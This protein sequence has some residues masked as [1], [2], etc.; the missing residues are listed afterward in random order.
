MSCV[1]YQGKQL[2]LLD[3]DTVLDVLLRNGH[4]IPHGCRAGAC[5]SCLMVAETGQVPAVAQQG[6][7][8]AQQQLNYFLSC[9]CLPTEP[10]HVSAV[11]QVKES[12]LGVIAEKFWFNDQVIC[13]RLKVADFTY[14]P[15]Q[16]VT[17]WNDEN[18]ARSYSIASLPADGYLEFHIKYHVDGQFSRWLVENAE[19]GTTLTVQGPLGECIYSAEEQQPILLAAIGTGLAPI[20]GIL[21]DALVKGHEGPIRV[22]VGARSAQSHYLVDELLCLAKTYAQVEVYLLAMDDN[23]E[24]ILQKDIYQF[25]T[26]HFG[27]LNGWKIYL[28]GSQSFVG[29]MRKRCFLNGARMQDIVAD[30]FL[31]FATA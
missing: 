1:I 18:L 10:L 11:A 23:K 25:C 28:C 24:R 8:S 3:G 31:P 27:E 4:A 7:N 22:V 15:G 29:K 16:Y 9:Q 12:N 13:L 5:Q 21:R 30:I 26:S 19:P 20:Y 2:S 14:Y 6:L 17:L